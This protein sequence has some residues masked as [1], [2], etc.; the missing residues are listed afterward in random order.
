M[1]FRKT[2]WSQEND[3]LL[4]LKFWLFLQDGMKET[5]AGL[6]KKALPLDSGN[7]ASSEDS[8][9][10]NSRQSKLNQ[11]SKEL[12]PATTTIATSAATTSSSS[13]STSASQAAA[14][15]S[16]STIALLSE[17]LQTN[18]WTGSDQSMFRAI[19]K[20]FLNNYCA[21][22][23]VMLTKTC[24]EVGSKEQ[25]HKK[26]KKSLKIFFF[27]FSLGLWIC[28]KRSRRHSN[29]RGTRRKYTAK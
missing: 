16:S 4:I 19:H 7:E 20:V 9:D 12:V 22:A 17:R 8:N 15:A 1:T 25:K 10:S 5:L 6:A 2:N 3:F 28:S 29:W 26:I 11:L 14:A 23:Q 27:V 18:T 24:Q 13:A 21:I